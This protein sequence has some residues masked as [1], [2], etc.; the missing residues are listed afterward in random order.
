MKKVLVLGAGFVA[1]PLVWYLLQETP[2]EVILADINLS[3]A[4]RIINNHPRGKALHLDIR[5]REPLQQAVSRVDL[6]VSLLPRIFHP[7]V[8]ELC[9]DEKKHL[10]TTS[11]VSSEMQ[12]LDEPA[13]CR[14]ILLLNE[15]GLDPGLDHMEAVR[16]ISETR[17]KGGEVTAFVSY[18]GGLPAPEARDNPF[19]YKFSW[20]PQ[21]ALQACQREARY[22]WEG[23]IVEVSGRDI[24]YH[25]RLLT[26]EQ[27]GSFEG[28]PNGDSLPYRSL[29]GLSQVRTLLRGTLRYPGWCQLMQTLKEFGLLD[30]EERE[31]EV[32]TYREFSRTFLQRKKLSVRLFQKWGENSIELAQQALQWLGFFD[33]LPLPSRRTSPLNLLAHLMVKKMQYQSGERDMIVLEH[34]FEV[35]AELGKKKVV[36]SLVEFGRP[37]GDSAMSRLVGLPA[38]VATRFI[39]EEKIKLTGVRIPV[40]EAIYQPVLHELGKMGINFKQREHSLT[41]AHQ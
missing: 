21:G 35:E 29:Y 30:E 20:S 36:S 10:V 7:R 15:I 39:L 41:E 26:I 11:Y 19:Q 25:G 33:D 40:E 18:C 8:A 9:V 27:V 13:R 3:A 14:G 17:R 4:Q 32:T 34:Q 37:Q 31:W 22:L 12:T 5:Q 28:Y 24:F 6:V 16:F 2:F 23:K 1:R 38:A